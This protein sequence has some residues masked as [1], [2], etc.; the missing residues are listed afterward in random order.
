MTKKELREMVADQLD[1]LWRMEKILKDYSLYLAAHDEGNWLE[2]E[3]NDEP[4]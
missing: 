3:N 1:L 2:S 4:F